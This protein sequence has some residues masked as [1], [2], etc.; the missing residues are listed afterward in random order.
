M[1]C[2]NRSTVRQVSR[3]LEVQVRFVEVLVRVTGAVSRLPDRV[4]VRDRAVASVTR[5][6]L[7]VVQVEAALLLRVRQGAEA[8]AEAVVHHRQAL[9]VTEAEI[10]LRRIRRPEVVPVEVVVELGEVLRVARCPRRDRRVRLMTLRMFRME[11]GSETLRI[12]GVR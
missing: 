5:L 3:P 7:M 12:N 9:R 2:G 1:P 4:R 8:E 6:D 11:S 10:S